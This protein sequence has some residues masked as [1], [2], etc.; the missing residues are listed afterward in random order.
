MSIG[1][2]GGG[3]IDEKKR[4]VLARARSASG[5]VGS[6]GG[7]GGGGV[8]ANLPGPGNPANNSVASPPPALGQGYGQVAAPT[9]G[10]VLNGSDGTDVIA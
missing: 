8:S 9:K 6:G 10:G 7:L 1:G 5:S 2:I 4:T 3:S